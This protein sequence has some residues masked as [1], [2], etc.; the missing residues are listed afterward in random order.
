M[1]KGLDPLLGPE[2]LMT[3]RAMGHGDEIA[4]VDANYPADAHATRLIRLDGFDAPR[5]VDAILSVMPLDEMVPETAFRPA[6][7]GDSAR[8]EPVMVDLQQVVSRHEPAVTL[9]ALVGEDFYGR[10]RAAYAVVASGE[11]RLYGNIIL[12]KGV[13]HPEAS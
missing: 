5:I 1:L 13:I 11:R 12:R 6:A 8:I 10:V 9:K 3:L 2:L 7:Y 4:I